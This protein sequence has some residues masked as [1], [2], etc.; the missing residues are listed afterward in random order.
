MKIVCPVCGGSG[1]VSSDFG[2]G[3]GGARPWNPFY[4]TSTSTGGNEVRGFAYTYPSKATGTYLSFRKTCPACCG[5]GV[6]EVSDCC[7]CHGRKCGC[8]NRQCRFQKKVCVF[9]DTV[10]EDSASHYI[11]F[12]DK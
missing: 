7:Y 12:S 9:E 2:C 3:C 10:R 5:T 6:Q 4:Y 8:C 1:S 11:P